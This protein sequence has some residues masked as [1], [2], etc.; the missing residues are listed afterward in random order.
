MGRTL[1][2]IS[3]GEYWIRRC[4]VGENIKL[5]E[6]SEKEKQGI[7]ICKICGILYS[8]DYIENLHDDN[9]PKEEHEHCPN[10]SF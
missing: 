2:N 3:R 8:S 5:N 1:Q 4:E 10:C 9:C 6:L 7:K